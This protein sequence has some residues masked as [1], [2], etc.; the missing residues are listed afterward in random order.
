MA[1]N[2]ANTSIGIKIVI[3]FLIIAFV[4]S[5]ISLSGLFTTGPNGTTGVGATDTLGR[6]NT[7]YQP[8]I[9]A[10]T[11]QLQSE[12]TSYTVLV[13]LGNAYF[14]WADAVSQAAQNEPGIAGADQPLWIASKD[15]Y[16]RAVEVNPGES[17]VMVDYAIVSHYTNETE[18]A[19]ELAESVMENDPEFAPAYFNAGIFYERVGRNDDALR[20]F[21]QYLELDPEGTQGNPDF[22]RQRVAELEAG[23]GTA[24]PAT[25]TAP[26]TTTP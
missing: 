23:A 2:K 18:Q 14:G 13:N 20:V 21:R 11:S 9:Q 5:F 15:A 22:A 12:P 3:V 26:A 1:L 10:L 24:A 16:R 25:P 8:T 17:P 19:I 4:M 7:Q 6:L